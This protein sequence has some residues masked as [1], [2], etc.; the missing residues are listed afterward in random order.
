MKDKSKNLNISQKSEGSS[1][2][3]VEAKEVKL[4][5]S[6]EEDEF[7]QPPFKIE[8]N[9][10]IHALKSSNHLKKSTLAIVE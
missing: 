5:F 7:V 2:M 8:K 9:N 1:R 10:K 4:Q 6:V 3:K